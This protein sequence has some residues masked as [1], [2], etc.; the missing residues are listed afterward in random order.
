MVHLYLCFSSQPIAL[1]SVRQ[2][3][4]RIRSIIN[5]YKLELDCHIAYRLLIVCANY[6][7]SNLGPQIPINVNYSARNIHSNTSIL[8][9]YCIH[10]NFYY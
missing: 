10:N 7:D 9:I 3:G 1:K 2:H 5:Y 4:R 8:I 6:I